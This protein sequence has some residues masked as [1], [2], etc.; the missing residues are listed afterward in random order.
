MPTPY[1]IMPG[2]KFPVQDGKPVLI[3]RGEFEECCCKWACLESHP[4]LWSWKRKY[5]GYEGVGCN[6]PVN[7]GPHID[8]LNY[9]GPVAHQMQEHL[10]S[11]PACLEDPWTSKWYSEELLGVYIG[12]NCETEVGLIDLV[13][14]EC[15]V[16]QG[17]DVGQGWEEGDRYIKVAS[18]H[19][20]KSE[21]E[22]ACGEEEWV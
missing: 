5:T 21:C 19:D 7:Y 10:A 20:L 9:N 22:A 17:W 11:L 2:G 14:H 18:L 3:S 6:G 16:N 8:C 15:R 4:L 13:L 1:Y 12:H